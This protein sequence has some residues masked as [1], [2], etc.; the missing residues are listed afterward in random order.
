MITTE[1]NSLNISRGEHSRKEQKEKVSGAR[2][3]S[4]RSLEQIDVIDDGYEDG[5][6]NGNLV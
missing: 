1:I 6:K 3:P 5:G 2:S 4:S